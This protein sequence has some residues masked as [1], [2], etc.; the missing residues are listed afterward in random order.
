LQRQR[1]AGLCDRE[2]QSYLADRFGLI[3]LERESWFG[4]TGGNLHTDH[5]RDQRQLGALDESDAGG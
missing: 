5:R 3:D 4:N 1:L 2:L